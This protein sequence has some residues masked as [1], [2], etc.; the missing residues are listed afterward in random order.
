MIIETRRISLFLFLCF[1][2]VL[3]TKTYA[4]E[5]LIFG[6]SVSQRVQFLISSY[7]PNTPSEDAYSIARTDLN[8]DQID[9]FILKT[10]DCTQ[11]HRLCNFI[12][13]AE[14]KDQMVELG[15][16]SAY[17]IMISDQYTDGIRNILAYQDTINDY[18]YSIY[19]WDQKQS[20]YI[21]KDEVTR[22]GT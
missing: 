1:F 5:V 17:N 2:S 9:E 21:L 8:A 12:A 11:P 19:V 4:Q 3:S 18:K 22:A 20:R 10:R 13:L 6:D 15:R 7:L 14:T 16:F